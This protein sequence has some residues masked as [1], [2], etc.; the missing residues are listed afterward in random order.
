MLEK[1]GAVTGVPNPAILRAFKCMSPTISE[2]PHAAITYGVPA[3]TT[4]VSRRRSGHLVTPP[5]TKRAR[6]QG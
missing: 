6:D 1:L 3:R 2:D 5:V 4:I